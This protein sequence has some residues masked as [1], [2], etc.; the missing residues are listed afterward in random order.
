VSIRL[1]PAREQQHLLHS[2]LLPA[3]VARKSLAP[4]Q[5]SSRSLG[6]VFADVLHSNG[7][8]F[9]SF[10]SVLHGNFRTLLKTFA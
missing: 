3:L 7:R 1:R 4:S 6:D 2:L 8:F 10:L 9:A 5:S